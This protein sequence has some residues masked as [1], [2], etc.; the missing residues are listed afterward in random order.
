ML[1]IGFSPIGRA[2]KS[3]SSVSPQKSVHEPR[4]RKRVHNSELLTFAERPL[5]S[6]EAALSALGLG[7]RFEEQRVF[8]DDDDHDFRPPHYD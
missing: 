4:A 3:N 6:R 7:K 8:G 1:S 2:L 5:V